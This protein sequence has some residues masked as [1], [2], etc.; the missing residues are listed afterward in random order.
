MCIENCVYVKCMHSAF[1]NWTV[2]KHLQFAMQSNTIYSVL[3]PLKHSSWASKYGLRWLWLRQ[4]NATSTNANWNDLM[5]AKLSS[6]CYINHVISMFAFKQRVGR[7]LLLCP[8]FNRFFPFLSCECSFVRSLSHPCTRMCVCSK[9]KRT[10]V[11]LPAFVCT[12]LHSS[13]STSRSRFDESWYSWVFPQK[14]GKTWTLFETT[15][16][17]SRFLFVVACF[18]RKK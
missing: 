14:Y 8:Y 13:L 3:L 17:F 9:C 11:I 5:Y 16:V 18:S 6:I 15:W 1:L 4:H 12:H 7:S 2:D 10:G